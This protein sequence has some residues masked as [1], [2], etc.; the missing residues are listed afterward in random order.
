MLFKQTFQSNFSYLNNKSV[1]IT[2]GTGTFGKK[3]VKTVLNKSSPKKLIIF[4]RDEFKQS[5]L[6]NELVQHK[7]FKILRFF[8]GDVRD[9]ERIRLAIKDVEIIV[10][11]AALKQIETAEYNPF[12]CINTNVLGAENIVRASLNSLIKKVI[13]ISTDKA[14]NP[15]N[16]YG[17]SKLAADKVFL[18]ANDFSGSN[19]DAIFSVVR[20]G[21][22]LGSRGS[23]IPFFLNL[24]RRNSKFF[25]ITEKEMTRFW[26]SPEE[27]V[28]FVMSSIENMV[29]G[30]VFIP[31]M[32]SSKIVDIA[33]SIDSSIPIKVIGKKFGEKMHESL[34]SK[35]DS[36]NTFESSDR[37]TILRNL[38]KVNKYKNKFKK[39]KKV[40]KDFEYNSLNTLRLDKKQIQKVITKI[41][42]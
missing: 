16:L 17:A 33:N 40:S 20:Y 15:I 26:I 22:V 28:N 34:I 8:I 3:F 31:K 7:N 14:V 36:S 23:V 32:P 18:A 21:N 41:S 5:E 24:K 6:R 35:D 37:F 19:N 39:F 4:S 9:L 38:K 29:G 27:S 13:A 2:G 12:E 11:A 10:H 1:L 25:P 42:S 30:E